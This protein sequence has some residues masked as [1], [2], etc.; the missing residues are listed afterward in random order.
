MQIAFACYFGLIARVGAT[1][2]KIVTW[3]AGAGPIGA[4]AK[5]CRATQSA[6]AEF[7]YNLRSG[8]QRR[9]GRL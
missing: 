4:Q 8:R 3:T 7:G 9:S 1:H 6:E 5:R 2:C